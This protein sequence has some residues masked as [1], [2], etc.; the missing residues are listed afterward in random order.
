MTLGLRVS[1]LA[2]VA[3]GCSP[4]TGARCRAELEQCGS[5]CVDLQSDPRH[6]GACE[7]A[8]GDGQSCVRGECATSGLD[9]GPDG[10]V[11]PMDADT[12][13][14][15]SMPGDGATDA[16][17]RPIC[18][19]GERLCEQWCVRTG[20]DPRHCGGCGNVCPAD[21]LCAAGTC[22]D[23]CP[24]PFRLC[25]ERCVD[26]RVDPE[27]CGSCENRC[28]TAACQAGICS[29][30]LFGH[31]LLIGHDRPSPGS[32]AGR[33]IANAIF[34]ASG[35]P[36]RVLAFEGDAG[37]DR[38]APIDAALDEWSAA[39]GRTWLR[40]GL[41]DPAETTA[42]LADADV[43]LIY[44]QDVAAPLATWGAEWARALRTFLGRGGVVV[45][46]EG[47]GTAT[48]RI[49]AG[50]GLL[51]VRGQAEVT[52]RVLTVSS[53]SDAAVLGVPLRYRAEATSVRFLSEPEGTVV[54]DGFGPVVVH[55]TVVLEGG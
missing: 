15:G 16:S 42:E 50:A 20:N 13:L 1:L 8:C 23:A 5:E 43:L 53:P 7:R 52:G 3:L 26:V 28:S 37:P 24:E 51:S 27:H 48:H 17:V 36:V 31:V 45:A 54:T 10:S 19:Q 29:R 22:V 30:L 34:V 9:G 47:V 25:G 46:L 12:T 40:R 32:P 4:V 35:N 2:L 41:R 38:I 33:I 55:R 14:D 18:D 6:C 39:S 49:L 11:T 44:P 21:Q